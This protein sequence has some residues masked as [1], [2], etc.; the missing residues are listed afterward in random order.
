MV[1]PQP[2]TATVVNYVFHIFTGALAEKAFLP[3]LPPQFPFTIRVTSQVLDSNGTVHP[4]CL[5]HSLPFSLSLF[6]TLPLSP[7]SVFLRISLFVAG[8][9]SM[10]TVCGASLALYD[11]GVTHNT[12]CHCHTCIRESE[13]CM[14]VCCI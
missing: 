7:T 1:G 2:S 10:A 12:A 5:T 8:S 3:V 4:L 6:L 9:S 14:N 11:A 13:M